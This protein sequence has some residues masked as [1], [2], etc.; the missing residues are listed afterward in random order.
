M[1]SDKEAMET[2]WTASG[3]D[4]SIA[5]AYGTSS[6]SA[7]KPPP[8][9]PASGAMPY[10]AIN[11]NEAHDPVAPR[12]QAAHIPQLIWNGTITRSPTLTSRTA[13]P[14]AMTSATPS[15]P[16]A[17]PRGVPRRPPAL[18]APGLA[19][20]HR[21]PSL[22]NRHIEVATGHGR[23]PHDRLSWCRD[24]RIRGV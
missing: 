16:T 15:W 18:V 7:I 5:S 3:I 20:R 14:T 22:G 12:R 10:I 11:G 24:L 21:Q 23:R 13:S 4:T 9:R 6:W 2:G 8:S 1:L 17:W 19:R